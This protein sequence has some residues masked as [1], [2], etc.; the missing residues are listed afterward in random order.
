MIKKGNFYKLNIQKSFLEIDIYKL[1][2]IFDLI[3]KFAFAILCFSQVI[4]S[5]LISIIFI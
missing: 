4:I 5:S 1:I 3:Q 2:D